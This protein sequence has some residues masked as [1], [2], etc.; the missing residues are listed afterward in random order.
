MDVGDVG[1]ASR[2]GRRGGD[3]EVDEEVDAAEGKGLGPDLACHPMPLAQEQLAVDTT[4][5]A[6]APPCWTSGP[7]P[8]D[9]RLLLLRCPALQLR[10]LLPCPRLRLLCAP[11]GWTCCL[12]VQ[13]LPCC[14]GGQA[15]RKPDGE[16][17]EEERR[18][19]TDDSLAKYLDGGRTCLGKE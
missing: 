2:A 7:Y 16:N 9:L 8:T 13:L 4:C 1:R 14:R 6:A 19:E 15:D 18:R 3:G 11:R 17:E 10:T 12:A 5:A